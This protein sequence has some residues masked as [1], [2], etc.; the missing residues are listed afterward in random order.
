MNQSS[1]ITNGSTVTGFSVVKSATM[2]SHI[3]AFSYLFFY[4]LHKKIYLSIRL[5]VSQSYHTKVSSNNQLSEKSV[6]MYAK[7]SC[8]IRWNTWS[9]TV[10]LLH[11]QHCHFSLNKIERIMWSGTFQSTCTWGLQTKD[12]K[13]KQVANCWENW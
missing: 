12:L 7:L 13:I 3:K 9:I 10:V 4:Q 8:E 11:I 2:Q 5:D 6:C 1:K